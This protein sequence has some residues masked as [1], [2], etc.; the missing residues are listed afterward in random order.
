MG[1]VRAGHIATDQGSIGIVGADSGME[2]RSPATWTD[3]LKVAGTQVISAKQ[4]GE[5]G[6]EGRKPM[7]TFLYFL[8]R[9]FAFFLSDI[10][11]FVNLFVVHSR[12]ADA[13]LVQT[14]R[15]WGK[16]SNRAAFAK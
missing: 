12:R 11:C 5:Q 9:C 15:Y 14:Q 8:C 2:H 13:K 16:C 4:E 3:N 1:D 10:V 6:L 7:L